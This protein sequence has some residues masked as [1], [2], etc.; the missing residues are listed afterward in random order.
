MSKET[1]KGNNMTIT[2]Q[3]GRLTGLMRKRAEESSNP[4]KYKDDP[5]GTFLSNYYGPDR[6]ITPAYTSQGLPANM[7]A[8]GYQ[9]RPASWALPFARDSHRPYRADI[10]DVLPA[11][12]TAGTRPPKKTPRPANVRAGRRPGPPGDGGRSYGVKGQTEDLKFRRRGGSQATTAPGGREVN[13]P[14]WY[15]PGMSR[16]P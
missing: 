6:P 4:V 9:G 7:Y 5:T 16:K 12:L 3:L 14:D 10:P 8:F 13:A 11:N 1:G 15:E 2:T